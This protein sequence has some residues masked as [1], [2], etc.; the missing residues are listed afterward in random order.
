VSVRLVMVAVVAQ[1]ICAQ[2]QEPKFEVAAIRPA[3]QDNHH[4]S[5][6]DKASW[7]GHNLSLKW[8][9][10]RAYDI[11]IG[12][13]SGG[14]KW[15][16]TESYDINAKIPEEFAER[17]A[18]V[19][20]VMMQNLLA[21]R[22]QLM[23]HREP[24]EVSGFELVVAEKGPKMKSASP[25]RKGSGTHTNNTHLKADNLTME[26]FAKN[27]SGQQDIGKLVVDKTGL[28]GGFDF[29]LD[30]SPERRGAGEG[31]ADEERPG[32]FTALQEQLG[33]KLKPAKI[34]VDAIVIDRAEKPSEN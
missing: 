13:V 2:S 7:R 16:D 28:S 27:L 29:E 15:V 9:I 21:E 8:L 14:P 32:I 26:S 5:N 19:I 1:V 23:I 25:D 30:W 22:F 12:L 3:T 10:A 6:S 20:E 33:L 4:N 11:D 34:R 17:K 24:R 31:A 18:A